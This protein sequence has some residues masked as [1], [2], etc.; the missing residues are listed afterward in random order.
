MA[1]KVNNKQFININNSYN[2]NIKMVE[3]PAKTFK[4]CWKCSKELPIGSTLPF[5]D[6]GCQ[7]EYYAENAKEIDS[8]WREITQRD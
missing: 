1:K 6:F 7:Q 3:I 4:W 8:V 5:C 2:N